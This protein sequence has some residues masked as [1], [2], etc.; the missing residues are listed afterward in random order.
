M[1]PNESNVYLHDTPA[2]S[3]FTRARRDFSHGCV[4]VDEPAALA[5]WVLQDQP[6][7]TPARILESMNGPRTRRV[8]LPRPIPVLL[9]YLTALVWPQDGSMHFADD[10]YGWDAR[11]EAA[12]KAG[13]TSS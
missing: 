12:L 7:W 4:R 5:A 13:R 11:L 9:V 1:F 10:I 3:L 8:D 2:P 6:E